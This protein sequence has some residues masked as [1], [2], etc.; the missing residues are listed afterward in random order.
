MRRLALSFVPRGFTAN[1][2]AMARAPQ[3]LVA[4]TGSFASPCGGKL[5]GGIKAFMHERLGL[6]W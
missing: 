6:G 5:R 1:C 2:G 4:N 3:S